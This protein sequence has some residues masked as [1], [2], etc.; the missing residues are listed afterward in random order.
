M[1]ELDPCK[2][3]IVAIVKDKI[4]NNLKKL[5]TLNNLKVINSIEVVMLKK[6]AKSLLEQEAE[7]YY[8]ILNS[9]VGYPYV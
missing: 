7:T 2:T 6:I 1:K 5:V 4:P 3:L 8:C 9:N